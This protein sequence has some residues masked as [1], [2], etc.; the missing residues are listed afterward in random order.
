MRGTFVLAWRLG[1][2][3]TDMD[4]RV[5]R[6]WRVERG[7]FTQYG[8]QDSKLNGGDEQPIGGRTEWEREESPVWQFGG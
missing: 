3:S 5:V 2:V 7:Y 4:A 6:E 1:L 8:D